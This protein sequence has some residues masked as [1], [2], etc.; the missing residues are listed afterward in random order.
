LAA[1]TVVLIT[2]VAAELAARWWLRHRN[3][4]YVCPPG[5]RNRAYPDPD[6]FP[7]LE[8]VARFEVNSDGER[9]DEV[10]RSADG[11]YRVLVGGGSMPEGFL[12]DQDTT[13]PGALQRQLEKPECLGM[14]GASKVHVGSISRSG[15]G[16]EALD[17]IFDRSLPRYPHLQLII[18]MVGVTDV[19]RWFEQGTP[20]VLAPVHTGD[21]FRYHP[22][23]PFGWQPTRLA[24]V[25]LL[26]AARQRW[27]RP[28]RVYQRAGR[29]LADARAM[30]ARA[31]TIRTTAPDPTPM[32]DHFERHFRRL[33]QT[34]SAHADRVLVIRQPWLDQPYSPEEMATMWHGG[35]GQAWHEDVTTYYAFEV[36]SSLMSLLDARAAKVAAELDVEQL[37]L[38]PILERT[39]ATYYDGFHLTPTGAQSVATAVGAAVLRQPVLAQATAPQPEA[40]DWVA[41]CK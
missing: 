30:R 38:M 16:A 5:Q 10:P 32:L 36:F 34:A 19:M 25:E 18:T 31:T 35:D 4:Y 6:V 33:L 24:V 29:W 3:Q 21:V 28:I 39:L 8:R 23:G 22:E 15:V 27:L 11:L 7:Q 14:L 37:D 12:L 41:L 9:G 20:Q 40:E 17:L 26:R 13:W 1:I 2:A